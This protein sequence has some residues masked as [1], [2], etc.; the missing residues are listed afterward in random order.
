VNSEP[1]GTYE[2][3]GI[4]CYFDDDNNADVIKEK[5]YGKWVI[6]FGV[7]KNRKSELVGK[8]VTWDKPDVDFRLVVS[9]GKISGWYRASSAE[10]WNQLGEIDLPA[11]GKWKI[12]LEACYGPKNKENW[13]SFSQFRIAQLGN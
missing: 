11:S 7:K 9:G 3:A 8:N 12:G 5:K 10:P 1:S 13:A 4:I 6:G 2:Q